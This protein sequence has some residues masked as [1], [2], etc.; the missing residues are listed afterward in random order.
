MNKQ[1]TAKQAKLFKFIKSRTA[2]EAD[3]SFE[4]MATHMKVTSK[5]SIYAMLAILERKEWIRK[6]YGEARAIEVLK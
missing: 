4:E 5:N 6:P 1:L 3:P 2:R